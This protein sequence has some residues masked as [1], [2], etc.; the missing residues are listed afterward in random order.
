MLPQKCRISAQKVLPDQNAHSLNFPHCR[1]PERPYPV[2]CR[3]SYCPNSMHNRTAPGKKPAFAP[4]TTTPVTP[5]TTQITK[6][7]APMMIMN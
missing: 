4:T 2:P 3:I 6:P 7:L 1:T 5:G